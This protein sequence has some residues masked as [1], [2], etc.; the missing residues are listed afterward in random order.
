MDYDTI[1]SPMWR[2]RRFDW[3]DHVRQLEHED[4]FEME[5]KMSINTFNELKLILQ[6]KLMRDSRR[7]GR[8]RTVTVEMIIALF[9]S[10]P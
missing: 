10:L 4:R 2:H 9:L 7:K 5:Y 6:Q 1:R 3:D 8:R